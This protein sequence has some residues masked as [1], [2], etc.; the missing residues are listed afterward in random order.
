[1]VLEAISHAPASCA[2]PTDRVAF[3]LRRVHSV[4]LD[5]SFVE[6]TLRDAGDISTEPR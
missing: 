4:S 6:A 1:M 2:S 5:P 3:V